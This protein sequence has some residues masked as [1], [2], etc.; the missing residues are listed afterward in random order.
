[1][2][3]TLS[4]SE[5]ISDASGLTTPFG[6]FWTISKQ[7]CPTPVSDVSP[8]T[9]VLPFVLEARSI[10]GQQPSAGRSNVF[11]SNT[12][13]SLHMSYATNLSASRRQ[14]VPSYGAAHRYMQLQQI[15]RQRLALWEQGSGKFGCS[16][17]ADV[18]VKPLQ[19]RRPRR[20]IRSSSEGPDSA[21]PTS[22]LHRRLFVRA[23]IHSKTHVPVGL[24]REFD[25][26]AL[27]A[28]I[29]DPLLSPRSRNFNR[30]ALLSKLGQ[31][32]GELS[33]H[34]PVDSS[35]ANACD[36]EDGVHDVN[37]KVEE[38]NTSPSLKCRR[39]SSKVTAVPISEYPLSLRLYSIPKAN[40]RSR[41]P[42]RTSTVT[43]V[44]CHHDVGSS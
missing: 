5:S 14:S 20:D 26:D 9:Q 10:G 43:S 33:S 32:D 13:E 15:Q 25:L 19:L 40:E 22:P 30:E 21:S 1:M 3:R 6:T 44:G 8:C 11:L 7:L 29:P 34:S 38:T 36:N 41:Y 23:V 37:I 28:T 24:K 2:I 12:A 31:S 16:E 27:R 35:M 18:F 4:V 42:I 39:Y 17:E